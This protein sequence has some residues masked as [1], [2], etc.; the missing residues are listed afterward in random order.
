MD[1]YATH[2]RALL[3]TVMATTGP[4]LELGCGDYSTPLLSAICE[5]Q[6]RPFKAQAS[7]AEWASRFPGVE[8][9]DWE[10]WIAPEGRW[11]LVFLDNEEHTL[12]R[13]RRLE[14]LSHI[15]DTIVLHDANVKSLV[16]IPGWTVQFYTQHKPH[17]AVLRKGA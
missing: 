13:Y 14:V 10:T 11:G 16:T 8:V 7:N 2:Q 1:P 4:V 12:K 5:S 9:V 6:G 3:E 15:T 17:T